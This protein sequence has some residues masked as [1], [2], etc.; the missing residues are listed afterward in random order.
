MVNVHESS[1][2]VTEKCYFFLVLNPACS[3]TK[4]A[5]L[6]M[7]RNRSGPKWMPPYHRLTTTSAFFTS[8]I[9]NKKNYHWK[10]NKNQKKRDG[11]KWVKLI[12]V[13]IKIT[14]LINWNWGGLIIKIW[15]QQNLANPPPTEHGWTS[16]KGWLTEEC[17]RGVRAWNFL[18]CFAHP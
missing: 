2:I 4:R 12:R 18:V 6:F 14:Q 17:T 3:M 10:K 5:A 8:I 7:C 9:W 11:M 16:L 15:I 1:D 13:A